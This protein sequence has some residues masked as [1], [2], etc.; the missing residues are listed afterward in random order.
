MIDVVQAVVEAKAKKIKQWPVRSNRASNLGHPCERYLVYERTH[1]QEKVLHD[2]GLQFIF[3]E[4]NIHEAAVI[5]DM[6]DAGLHVIEQQ[7][8]FEWAKYSI[9][10]HVDGKLQDNGNI[11]PFE[12]K[13]MSDWAWKAVNNLEDMA[14]SK[15]IYM[16][17]YPAQLNLYLI[18]D[19]KDVGLFILKNKQ[20]GMLK[21]VEVHLDYDYTEGLIKKAERING[22]V[23]NDTLPDRIPWEV[24]ACEYCSYNHICLPPH[25]HE[26]TLIDDPDLEA[27]LERRAQLKE[28]V[29]E[30]DELDKEIRD[31]VKEK[32][33]VVVGNWQI[34]GKW[35]EKKE[36]TVKASKYWTTTI[37][38]LKSA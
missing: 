33:E 31:K 12:I 36:Y 30:Y 2:V 1:W 9:T 11:F 38:K 20:T 3:D 21:Q 29:T 17:Q 16:R 13:S 8:A 22:H 5:R 34:M 28:I 24:G 23:A 32:P 25:T 18:M 15:S 35:N 4:G 37:R 26:A 27:K 7:R 14:K 10:G 19:E 6:Q